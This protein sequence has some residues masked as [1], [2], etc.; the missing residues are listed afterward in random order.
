[1]WNCEVQLVYNTFHLVRSMRLRSSDTTFPNL[2]LCVNEKSAV[3]QVVV[4]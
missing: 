3:L 2:Y 1:M 4:D